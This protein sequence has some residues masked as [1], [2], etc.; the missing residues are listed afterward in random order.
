MRTE[1]RFQNV[2]SSVK[3]V[4]T[5]RVTCFFVSPKYLD[6]VPQEKSTTFLTLNLNLSLSGQIFA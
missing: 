6:Q 5:T 4:V 1:K 3:R 2:Q